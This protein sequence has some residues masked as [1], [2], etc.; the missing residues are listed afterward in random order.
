[1]KLLNPSDSLKDLEKEAEE[2]K[3][4]VLEQSVVKP[5][6]DMTLEELEDN[7][8]EFNKEDEHA[9]EM[10][11]QQRLAEWKATKLRNKCR[12]VLAISG[13]DYFQQGDIKAQFIGPLVFG[14]MNLITNELEWKL[15]E[16]GAMKIDLKENRKKPIEHELLFSVRGSVPGRRDSDCKD[17]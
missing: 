2:Q 15:S 11:R 6:V 14:G 1:M 4:H 12:E 5:Y 8:I 3:Q 10:N 9:I 17:D 13:K 16:S 7:E